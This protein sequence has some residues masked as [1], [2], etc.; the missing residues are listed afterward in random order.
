MSEVALINGAPIR[1][2]L[3]RAGRFVSSAATHLGMVR[4]RNEDNFVNRPDLGVWAVADGAGGHDAGDVAARIA[5]DALN[6]MPPGLAASELLADARLRLAAAHDSIRAEAAR[7]GAHAILAT[8]VVML[9]AHRDHFACLWAGDSRA[10]LLRDGRLELLSH[11]HSLVQELVDT[12]ALRP[13]E[14]L[15]HPR[16][17]VITRALGAASRRLDLDKISDRLRPGDRFLLCSD[18]VSKV[19]PEED[20]ALLLGSDTGSQ[21][22]SLVVAALDRHADDNV[23]SVTIEV[24]RDL[25]ETDL[26]RG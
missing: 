6:G 2:T 11:D 26:P 13:E 5:T 3:A 18:G 4:S 12:G 23:T 9:L 10:Y 17:N 7:R 22:E 16:A 19:L 8:T 20:I 21:A 25:A 1:S 15:H 24:F 14:A